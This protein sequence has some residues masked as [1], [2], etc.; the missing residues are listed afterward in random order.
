M[1]VY[2]PD[3]LNFGTDYSETAA[4]PYIPWAVHIDLEST[5][6]DEV[7]IGNIEIF[8][9]LK[10]SSQAR[11]DAAAAKISLDVDTSLEGK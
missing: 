10:I 11:K 5:V 7:R 6:A 2:Q 8:I 4:E 9:S 3:H 1:P